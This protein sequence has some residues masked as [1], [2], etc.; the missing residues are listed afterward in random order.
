MWGLHLNFLQLE[1]T[2]SSNTCTVG[3]QVEGG[4]NKI[5]KTQP[6]KVRCLLEMA[7]GSYSPVAGLSNIN[8][9]QFG[10][11]WEKGY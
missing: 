9:S 3:P 5:K 7:L 1:I 2:F 11:T 8:T 6:Q 10:L 4:G